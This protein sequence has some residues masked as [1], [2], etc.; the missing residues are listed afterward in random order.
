MKTV[1]SPISTALDDLLC[2]Y[3]LE[4]LLAAAGCDA[5]FE[6]PRVRTTSTDRGLR[7]AG[8]AS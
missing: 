4:P 7:L 6:L 8:D 5:L 2:G 1:P 3:I